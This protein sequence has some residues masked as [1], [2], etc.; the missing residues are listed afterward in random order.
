[1]AV[2]EPDDATLVARV[3]RGDE[4][5]CAA[6]YR[7]HFR[8]ARHAIAQYVSNREDQ[9][10]IAQ[11]AFTRAFRRIDGLREP[12]LF[13]AWLL[14]TARNAALD[15]VRQRQRRPITEGD[16]ALDYVETNDD[17]VSA[18]AEVRELAQR[19]RLAITALSPR[20][21]TVLSMV[22]DLGFGPED[23]AASLGITPNNAKVI[24]HRA[25]K[26]LKAVLELQEEIDG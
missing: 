23:V 16:E 9:L 25:R 17:D 5:A 15:H 7:R 10:D 26:R 11:I 12:E 13:R 4:A 22:V 2:D 18:V 8:S 19:V 20:D 6:L 24:V 3:R 14:Q 1:M 21:A